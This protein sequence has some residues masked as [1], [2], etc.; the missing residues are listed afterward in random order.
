MAAL[1]ASR[2]VCSA[3]LRIASVMPLM[4]SMDSASWLTARLMSSTD[5][6]NTWVESWLFT[7]ICSL[8]CAS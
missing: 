6:N 1:R 7:A 4:D 5:T 8:L 3:M 2:L